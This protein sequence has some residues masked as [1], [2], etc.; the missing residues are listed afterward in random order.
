MAMHCLPSCQMCRTLVHF[1]E[2]TVS[3]KLFLTGF[4][5]SSSGFVCKCVSV[6]IKWFIDGLWTKKSQL[7]VT[8]NCVWVSCIRMLNYRIILNT[9][10]ADWCYISDIF[11]LLLSS[12]KCP[13]A[14]RKTAEDVCTIHNISL[15]KCSNTVPGLGF[16]FK[17]DLRYV[18]MTLWTCIYMVEFYISLFLPV[19][20]SELYVT[21]LTF[22][23]ISSAVI[24]EVRSSSARMLL[25]N[26]GWFSLSQHKVK[27]EILY[28][29]R[30]LD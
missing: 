13:Q 26:G 3:R 19:S 24:Y 22:F 20:E 12:K 16:S 10:Q 9:C 30:K 7:Y 18:I 17:Y 28:S 2:S 27:W 6:H 25:H 21:F 1:T 8:H 23:I 5:Y 29:V 14:V 15:A 11:S 4:V